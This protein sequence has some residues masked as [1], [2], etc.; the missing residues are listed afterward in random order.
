MLSCFVGLFFF[1]VGSCVSQVLTLALSRTKGKGECVFPSGL[2]MIYRNV[3]YSRVPT[4]TPFC[5]SSVEITT[6]D[7]FI[8]SRLYSYAYP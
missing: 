3:E 5:S 7:V 4:A 2:V 6:P 1:F 8:T